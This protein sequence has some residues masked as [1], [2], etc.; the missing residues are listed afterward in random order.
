MTRA[1]QRLNL[2]WAR[3]R[4][5]FGQRRPSQPSRFLLEVP[6]DALAV[7]ADADYAAPSS[8]DERP[9]RPRYVRE[10]DV[11]VAPTAGELDELRPGVK[12]RHP[13]FG[14]GTVVNSEGAGLDKKLTVSFRGIGAKRLVARYAALEVL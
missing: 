13:L 6:R 8:Y 12:V 7:S 4:R 10:P 2:S 5:V 1:R 11:V 3:T 9:S 14:E